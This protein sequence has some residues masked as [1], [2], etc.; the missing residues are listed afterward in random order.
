[1]VKKFQFLIHI[2]HNLSN[3]KNKK[4]Q[5]FDF[6]L[7]PSAFEEENILFC[8]FWM[9]KV[10]FSSLFFEFLL[11]SSLFFHPTKKILVEQNR[12]WKYSISFYTIL[13]S[14]TT[15]QFLRISSKYLL[16]SSILLPKNSLSIL[17]HYIIEDFFKK[18]FLVHFTHIL[19]IK[20]KFIFL[21]L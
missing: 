8:S 17:F 13:N 18:R 11:C 12:R 5:S 21:N 3:W 7:L 4:K 20:K 9:Q 19:Y 14:S 16:N 2:F 6:L 15:F 1:M 10:L